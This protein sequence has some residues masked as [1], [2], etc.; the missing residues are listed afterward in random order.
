MVAVDA[1]GNVSPISNTVTMTAGGTG[2][3]SGSYVGDETA[4][5]VP[6]GLQAVVGSDL[7]VVLTWTDP[8]ASDLSS[9]KV[10]RTKGTA[11]EALLTTVTKGL[12]TYTDSDVIA[13]DI[14]KYAITSVDAS[15]NESAKTAQVEVTVTAGAADEVEEEP[16]VEEEPVEEVVVGEEEVIITTESGE[17]VT[18]SDISNHWRRRN[19]SNG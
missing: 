10:Y 14:V 17:E 18:L 11:T 4:P 13:G 1:A 12:E 3:G 19:Y 9:V 5:A 7:K 16:A 6:T 2:L 8:T 15:G